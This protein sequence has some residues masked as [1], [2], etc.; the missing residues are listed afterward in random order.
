MF[1][2]ILNVCLKFNPFSIAGSSLVTTAGHYIKQPVIHACSEITKEI[3]TNVI[4][5]ITRSLETG[6]WT[7]NCGE[8]PL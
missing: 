4:I 8:P 3:I 7:S 2:V 5:K 1:S 6:T